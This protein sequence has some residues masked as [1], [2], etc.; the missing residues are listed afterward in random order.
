MRSIFPAS[1]RRGVWPVSYIANLI[2]DEPPLI[3]KTNG[4]P[5][6]LVNACERSDRRGPLARVPLRL[7]SSIAR[8]HVTLN[9][10]RRSAAPP[11]HPAGRRPAGVADRAL[12]EALHELAPAFL[13]AESMCPL[14][15]GLAAHLAFV[16]ALPSGP[17]AAPVA[18]PI[19]VIV[20]TAPAVV[21][22]ITVPP[23]PTMGPL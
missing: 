6:S 17:G 11:A 14:D 2:L 23:V 18:T 8:P 4:R 19:A 5:V 20:P 10:A 12:A 13:T 16:H 9:R 21:I 22:V 3:A 7:P 15:Q 1:A